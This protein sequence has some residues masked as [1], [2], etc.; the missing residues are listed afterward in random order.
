MDIALPLDVKAI[1]ALL[2]HR[3]PFLLVE[4]VVALEPGASITALKNVSVNEPFFQGHFPGEPVMPGVLLLEGMAQTGILLACLT[5]PA[6]QGQVAY[7]AG[8]DKARFRRIVRPGDRLE[9]KLELLKQKGKVMK[10]TGKTFVDGGLAAEAE[11]M[12][13]YL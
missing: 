3:Y 1:M 13:S 9:Y 11:L 12:A 2:P 8:V 4:R 6:L 7:F 5:D 10:M